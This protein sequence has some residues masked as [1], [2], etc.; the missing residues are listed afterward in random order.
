MGADAVQKRKAKALNPN[1]CKQLAA[2]N[3]F[4]APTSD[5]EPLKSH[6]ILDVF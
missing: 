1:K 2:H 6:W 3:V 5:P 4:E